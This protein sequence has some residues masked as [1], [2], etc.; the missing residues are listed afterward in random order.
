LARVDESGHGISG[1]LLRSNRWFL[2]TLPK[3]D[4][5]FNGMRR[6]KL[7]VV[8]GMPVDVALAAAVVIR[9]TTSWFA[10][11]LGRLTVS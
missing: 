8:A 7:L 6:M 9:I 5:Y 1:F 10:V 3:K 2:T 11:G 4:N